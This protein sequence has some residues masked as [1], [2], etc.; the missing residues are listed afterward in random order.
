MKCKKCKNLYNTCKDI[1]LDDKQ[2]P[3]CSKCRYCISCR[4]II[5]NNTCLKCCGICKR[6]HN[7][8]LKYDWPNETLE[9]LKN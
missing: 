1:I 9:G 8:V 6:C 4:K 5:K 3:I 7:V 2:E